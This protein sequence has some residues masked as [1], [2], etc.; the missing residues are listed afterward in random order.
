MTHSPSRKAGKVDVPAYMRAGVKGVALVGGLLE[1]V[2]G[3]ST[4]PVRDLRTRRGLE[5]ALAEIRRRF[6]A[7]VDTRLRL[8][9]STA[10]PP[11]AKKVFAQVRALLEHDPEAGILRQRWPACGLA[12][13]YRRP[14]DVS[15]TESVPTEAGQAWKVL[16]TVA[17]ACHVAPREIT[18]ARGLA[19]AGARALRKLKGEQ[20]KAVSAVAAIPRAC[21]LDVEAAAVAL[22]HAPRERGS[23]AVT[24]VGTVEASVWRS[25]RA[26][27]IRPA[28]PRPWHRDPVVAFAMAESAAATI[29]RCAPYQ[30]AATADQIWTQ[31]LL[32]QTGLGFE[33]YVQRPDGRVDHVEVVG[34]AWTAL[35]AAE[36]ARLA[37]ISGQKIEQKCS[38]LC[39]GPG[40]DTDQ[41]RIEPCLAALVE[42]GKVTAAEL[43]RFHF[44]LEGAVRRTTDVGILS[45]MAGLPSAT[46]ELARLIEPIT[47]YDAATNRRS[48]L[49]RRHLD[50]AVAAA[51][52]SDPAAMVRAIKEPSTRA[53]VLAAALVGPWEA[54]SEVVALGEPR[55]AVRL[56]ASAVI[57][58]PLSRAA[59]LG[60][61]VWPSS[62]W[63][64]LY[65]VDAQRADFSDYAM[66]A[67]VLWA[68]TPSRPAMMAGELGGVRSGLRAFGFVAPSAAGP[69]DR[70][71][72]DPDA[73]A[74]YVDA[75]RRRREDTVGSAGMSSDVIDMIR[76]LDTKLA[77]LGLVQHTR[78]VVRRAILVP[79]GR[80]IPGLERLS[81][82]MHRSIAR[83]TRERD[84]LSEELISE[85]M[86]ESGLAAHRDMPEDYPNPLA[87]E[88]C[89]HG[90][91][92]RPLRDA[93]DIEQ[94]AI[95]MDSCVASYRDDARIGGLLLYGLR[96][97]SGRS[98][99][100]L[101]VQYLAHGIEISPFQHYGAQHTRV[102]APPPSGHQ[103][104]ASWLLS[105]LDRPDGTI[106][107]RGWSKAL[108][109][110]RRAHIRQA[111]S[112]LSE[113]DLSPARRR[114][115]STLDLM[116][117]GCL[118][119]SN[120]RKLGLHQFRIWAERLAATK[121]R[122][123]G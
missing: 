117:L 90:V 46:A 86:C 120:E 123:P 43:A 39:R 81:S 26:T 20:K 1:G 89:Y 108:G 95:E 45:F 42:A 25:S 27:G 34:R 101:E 30:I 73:T 79:P 31:A 51:T 85:E 70:T 13:L 21:A 119:G 92:I 23:V 110:S 3:L 12:L 49:G 96:S 121:V 100:G 114:R 52:H 83:M 53:L 36:A 7:P 10:T 38:R 37:A 60:L 116:H 61:G 103:E 104:A 64:G 40:A 78:E 47:T 77:N 67:A 69:G 80:M 6:P 68:G 58:R 111:G 82:R 11:E 97:E 76:F 94:E 33:A 57:D 75:L 4:C 98:T 87:R 18:T 44:R 63:R 50:S 24:V 5:L 2:A 9:I 19:V 99:L 56:F 118:L 115:L 91:V 15:G 71:W 28:A 84:A 105:A 59:A 109:A 29:A 16:T 113:R 65:D 88:I 8:S 41:A 14:D 122:D 32:A 102:D 48:A 66:L 106:V 35:G 62:P 107:D 22:A 55:E 17:L 93:Q 74:A 72:D 54:A 112:R